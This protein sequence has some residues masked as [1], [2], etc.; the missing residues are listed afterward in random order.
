MHLV[1]NNEKTIEEAL[2]YLKNYNPTPTDPD[3]W[4]RVGGYEQYL[5]RWK[6]E[7]KLAYDWLKNYSLS[8]F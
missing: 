1:K 2:D 5:P 6:A 4:E 8:H 3:K 7:A